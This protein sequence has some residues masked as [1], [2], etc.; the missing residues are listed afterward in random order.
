MLATVIVPPLTGT[1]RRN[2]RSGELLDG[3]K[4][5]VARPAASRLTAIEAHV[6][7]SP[8]RRRHSLPASCCACLRK[9]TI[10]GVRCVAHEGSRGRLGLSLTAP[11]PPQKKDRSSGVSKCCSTGDRARIDR[12]V[13]V[14]PSFRR[15]TGIRRPAG[16]GARN[17]TFRSLVPYASRTDTA[18]SSLSISSLSAYRATFNREPLDSE[19]HGAALA[20]SSAG[21]GRSGALTIVGCCRTTRGDHSTGLRLLS[22]SVSFR[23]GRATYRSAAGVPLASLPKCPLNGAHETRLPRR[24]IPGTRHGVR[25]ISPSSP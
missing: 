10:D 11:A 21:A 20:I 5:N 3:P 24:G 19:S 6:S 16:I 14:S 4:F 2:H 17:H 15:L 23:R 18:H 9:G 13:V 12:C 7:F 25:S 1:H 22:T 8:A